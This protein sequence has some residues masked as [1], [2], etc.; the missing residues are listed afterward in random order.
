MAGK[1]LNEMVKKLPKV[2]ITENGY[3]GDDNFK[4]GGEKKQKG[5]V[6]PINPNTRVI[7]KH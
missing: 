1:K 6:I 4:R 2:V 7:D 3:M 5:T